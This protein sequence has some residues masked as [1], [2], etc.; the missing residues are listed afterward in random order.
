M[1]ILYYARR[2][3]AILSCAALA[4]YSAKLSWEHTQ[5]LYGPFAAVGAV[6]L[7]VLSHHCISDRQSGYGLV[8]GG[9]G[10]L[11]AAISCG[12]VAMRV[13]DVEA[14]QVQQLRNSNIPRQQAEL[15][16]AKA[17]AEVKQAAA[18]TRSECAR[19]KAVTACRS[20]RE[21]EAAARTR[22]TEA[23]TAVAKAGAQVTEAHAMPMVAA[24]LPYAFPIWTEL[25]AAALGAFG[26]APARNHRQVA[27]ATASQPGS[28]TDSQPKSA[29]R[30]QPRAQPRS[31]PKKGCGRKPRKGTRAYWL[32]RLN[33]DRPD[34]AALVRGGEMSVNLACI[35]AG[36][37]KSP[38]RLVASA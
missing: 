1:G 30:S 11:A 19:P 3:V 37:R 8:L 21:I 12:V 34:L 16:L 28:A 5:Q 29:T 2:G 7:L 13:A 23:R 18:H 25:A 26:F 27:P 24:A 36:W 35:R 38:V 20:A 14:G 32:Q 6:V 9:L 4:W 22:Q 10:L 15:A 33:R 17:E 31:Q